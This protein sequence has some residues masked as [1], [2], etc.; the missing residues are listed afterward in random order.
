MVPIR[1]KNGVFAYNKVE[2]GPKGLNIDQKGLKIYENKLRIVFLDPKYLFIGG[3]FCGI[4]RYPLPPLY[5]FL[6][7]GS[8][9]AESS[10]PSPV[11]YV[12]KIH[13]LLNLA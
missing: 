9:F 3:F 2:N 11:R 7:G 10:P 4:G 1:A 6:L 8:N 12:L 5:G 13:F